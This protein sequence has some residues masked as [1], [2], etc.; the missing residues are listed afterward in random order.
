VPGEDVE[1]G[2][3]RLDVHRQVRDGLGA[4]DEDQRA[5][6]VGHLDHLADRVD[7]SQ[8]VR[9]VG[10]RHQLRAQAEEH[11][12]DVQ[13]EKP[14]VRDGDELQV[15]VHFLGQDLPRDQVRVVFHLREDDRVTRADI[16]AAPAVGDQV[17]GLGRVAGP[18][19]L[20]GGR[21]VDEPC[22][23]GTGALV[24]LRRPLADLVDGAVHVRVVLA[25]VAV[26]RL[27]DG[28][29]LLAG[30]GRVQVDQPLP[31][32]TLLQDREVG[33]EGARVQRTARV[34]ARGRGPAGARGRRPAGAGEAGYGAGREVRH[35]QCA[36]AA[37]SASS[38]ASVSSAS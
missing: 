8:R 10:E 22:D 21:R 27:Y 15:A 24:L 36:A 34:G 1:V 38:G 30:G 20:V 31:V 6:R 5:R 23:P 35:G 32:R 18:H 25:V 7:G 13:A 17:D 16:P 37:G 29:R 2:T 3:Q 28:A 14:V 33:R 26:H 4:V 12:E 19:D 9:D 11:L